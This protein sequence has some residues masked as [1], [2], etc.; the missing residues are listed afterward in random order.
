M[1]QVLS[2]PEDLAFH[3]SAK[4]SKV[5]YFS[6]CW[7]ISTSSATQR[8]IWDRNDILSQCYSAEDLKRCENLLWRIQFRL[9]FEHFSTKIGEEWQ[10]RFEKYNKPLLGPLHWSNTTPYNEEGLYTPSILSSF[11]SFSPLTPQS[12]VPPHTPSSLKPALKRSRTVA[13]ST[14]ESV[15]RAQLRL[16]YLDLAGRVN[17]DHVNN[18]QDVLDVFMPLPSLPVSNGRRKKCRF[19][20]ENSHKAE[21]ATFV[22]EYEDEDDDE[23]FEVGDALMR[24]AEGEKYGRVWYGVVRDVEDEGGWLEWVTN[25]VEMVNWAAGV[26]LTG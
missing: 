16:Y 20:I 25:V 15:C 10:D 7:T 14:T 23:E 11:S 4:H 12:P 22:A 17:M 6:H 19:I 1:R 2:L 9:L 3:L 18:C 5:D 24:Y 8:L 13:S 21:D 26:R